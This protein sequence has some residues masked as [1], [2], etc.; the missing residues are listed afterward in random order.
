MS[1]KMYSAGAYW[2]VSC[3]FYVCS[4]GEISFPRAFE[5]FSG[6]EAI[7]ADLD[8]N[9]VPFVQMWIKFRTIDD[10]VDHNV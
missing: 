9:M 2:T 5:F 1:S 8:K 4:N 7:D 6:S 3:L 10:G